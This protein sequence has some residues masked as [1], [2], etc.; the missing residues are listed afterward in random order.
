MAEYS[1]LGLRTL[2]YTLVLNPVEGGFAPTPMGRRGSGFPIGPIGTGRAAATAQVGETVDRTDGVRDSGYS[3][4]TTP[5]ASAPSAPSSLSGYINSLT[6]ALVNKVEGYL[7]FP[8]AMNPLTGTMRVS[9][10]S[11]ALA[12]IMPSFF[13]PLMDF[14]YKANM[15]NLSTIAGLS[16]ISD[17]YSTG[18][19]GN[20]LVGVQPTDTT[21]GGMILESLGFNVEGY[22]LSGNIGG[23]TNVD[24]KAYE[25]ALVE[26][27]LGQQP[28]QLSPATAVA[29]GFNPGQAVYSQNELIQG[30]A[31]TLGIDPFSPSSPYAF[32]GPYA[33]FVDPVF[34]GIADPGRP[35]GIVGTTD[36]EGNWRGVTSGTYTSVFGLPGMTDFVFHNMKP[37]YSAKDMMNLEGTGTPGSAAAAAHQS[38]DPT[39]TYGA[40]TGAPT[41]MSDE[42]DDD[43]DPGNQGHTGGADPS[44]S[45]AE[46]GGGYGALG[47][48][49][50]GRI[51]YA[52]GGNVTSGFVNKDPD[53]VTEKQSIADNRFTSIKEGSFIVNQP[54]NEKYEGMLDS[55]VAKAKKKAKKPKD[56]PMVDVALSDGERHIEPEVVAEIEKMKG[57][58][59]L[60]NLNDKGKAEVQRR[61]NKYGGGVG[62]NEGGIAEVDRGLVPQLV[63]PDRPEI[64]GA[65]TSQSL[66]FID[67][68]PPSIDDDMY[69]GRKFG[70]IKSAIQSVEIK[71]FEDNPFIFTGIKR[72]NKASSAFGPMQITAS[73][74]KD[75]KQRSK[76]YNMLGSDEKQYMDLLI[77][78]GDDKVNI[79]KYRSMYRD[80]KKVNTPK[81][82]K[83]L[84]GRYGTGQIDPN[85]HVQ[86]Y[87]TIANITLMQKLQDHKTLKDALASYGEG[88][89]YATKVL[90]ALK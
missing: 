35:G 52:P 68:P 20:Q 45:Q 27:L 19:V 41:G 74:L 89:N 15:E 78:Q 84:Y 3:T 31:T 26:N 2:P 88:T 11:P 63:G 56:A 9:G 65:P 40:F 28:T 34:G 14:A 64:S 18:L 80:G 50:G 25:A 36:A 72:K 49:L 62:L 12:G 54:T 59:F 82:I 79:E 6:N 21:F 71:G 57:K 90:S 83:K 22:T 8:E 24:Q 10:M 47:H 87:D 53:S 39:G 86:Y 48:A 5:S 38:N 7:G 17:E 43:R 4:P 46:T 69:F 51:A 58:S 70:D 60:D 67:Q 30:V 13:G 77:Q 61:Q 73:T 44:G 23:F 81:D 55:L 16:Q 29:M 76:F 32:G 1:T 33:P 37:G 85:L 42:Y 75:I 66:G